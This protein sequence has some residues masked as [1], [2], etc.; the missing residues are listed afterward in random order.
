[1][2]EK[3]YKKEAASLFSSFGLSYDESD[4]TAYELLKLARDLATFKNITDKE[5]LAEI[6]FS[7]KLVPLA[8]G[9]LESA[10]A[11]GIVIK[12]DD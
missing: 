10:K 1:M 11:L 9:T 3:K 6:G 8:L 7:E 12:E 5:A 2:S 4:K